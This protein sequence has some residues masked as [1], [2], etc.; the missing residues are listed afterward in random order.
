MSA[1]TCSKLNFQ[2]R[3]PI[4]ACGS[5]GTRRRPLDA[6]QAASAKITQTQD[7]P[8]TLTLL[9]DAP[10]RTGGWVYRR[11]LHSALCNA[12]CGVI[13]GT[14]S[15]LADAVWDV[16]NRRQHA[17]RRFSLRSVGSP[18]LVKGL[19]FDHVIIADTEQL[20]RNNLN[21]ALTRGAKS[22]TIISGSATLQAA[23]STP[24]PAQHT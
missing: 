5:A 9:E 1:L 15:T 14:N 21:V 4:R 22:V 8:P 11:E 20:E 23:R 19:E 2:S 24:A 10:R 17:G 6:M 12:L 3:S 16:Q 7:L 13:T 18:L